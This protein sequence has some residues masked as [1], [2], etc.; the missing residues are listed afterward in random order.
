MCG[1]G[2]QSCALS[3]LHLDCQVTLSQYMG[4]HNFKLYHFIGFRFFYHLVM[5]NEKKLS[6]NLVNDV[7]T[8]HAG[9]FRMLFFFIC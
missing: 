2:V 6:R 4:D 5:Q 1:R 8:L 3:M 7:L 9:K